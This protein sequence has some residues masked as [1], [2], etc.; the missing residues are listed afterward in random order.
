MSCSLDTDTGEQL[1]TSMTECFGNSPH[2]VAEVRTSCCN[3][4][5]VLDDV[6]GMYSEIFFTKTDPPTPIYPNFRGGAYN[7]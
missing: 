7:G 3:R 2:R 5:L 4:F 6:I 1:N